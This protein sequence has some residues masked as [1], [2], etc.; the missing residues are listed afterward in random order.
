[1]NTSINDGLLKLGVNLQSMT[2]ADWR[3]HL[4]NILGAIFKH[5][6][7]GTLVAL[8]GAATYVVIEDTT[9]AFASIPLAL[10]FVAAAI[11]YFYFTAA[12]GTLLAA[13]QSVSHLQQHFGDDELDD[14]HYRTC[15][16][17]SDL[18]DNDWHLHSSEENDH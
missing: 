13:S 18:I 10:V 4:Q 11:K 3:Q 7:Q 5:L 2:S 14:D 1:M 9:W 12:T 15:P 6:V 8:G 16:L 17:H